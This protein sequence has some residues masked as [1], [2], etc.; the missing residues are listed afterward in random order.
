[1]DAA[2]K[3]H[4]AAQSASSR[5][6][7]DAPA[8]ASAD[9]ADPE[10]A[11]AHDPAEAD[12]P[13]ASESPARPEAAGKPTTTSKSNPRRRRKPKIKPPRAVRRNMGHCICWTN[14]DVLA[15]SRKPN[16]RRISGSLLE[17]VIGGHNRIIKDLKDDH[18]SR[19]RLIEFGGLKWIHKR[20][21]ATGLK[22][23]LTHR[24]GRTPAWREWK[25][26]QVL[27]L[28]GRR[29]SVPLLLLHDLRYERASQ[30]LILPYV[31]GR[32]LDRFIAKASPEK[33]WTDEHRRLRRQLA[34]AIGQQVGLI[35]ADGF[36]NRDHKPTN[37][38]IDQACLEDGAEPVII[39]VAGLRKR[40]S[41]KQV[42]RMLAVLMRSAQRVGVVTPVEALRVL[43]SAL[44]A[45][46]TLARGR[47]RRL[48]YAARQVTRHLNARGLSDHDE[49]GHRVK[50]KRR[51]WWP[52]QSH[53]PRI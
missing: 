5:L 21:R 27:H 31:E 19:V 47:R 30:V 25:G 52:F 36:V 14:P 46:P 22:S 17:A 40:G 20:Y 23:R 28:A 33:D 45:D 7:C 37:L 16:G 1:M 35:T 34:R 42:F 49:H 9:D 8:T 53:K 29:T 12:A 32:T 15:E 44:A 13:L 10:Q 3:G 41:D 26:A 2:L 11:E 24:F 43:K 48:R 4:P 38:V 6:R 18:R 39:D 51:W 50:K